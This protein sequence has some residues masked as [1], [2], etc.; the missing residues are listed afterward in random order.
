MDDLFVVATTLLRPFTML[1]WA[2]IGLWFMNRVLFL[3]L[4]H[5][6][7]K[8]EEREMIAHRLWF[9][10]EGWKYESTSS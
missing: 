9:Y 5:E 7:R 2:A 4:R 8:E 3:V 10:V 6:R 1:F